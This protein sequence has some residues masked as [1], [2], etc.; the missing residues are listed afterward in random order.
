MFEF[1][2]A[3]FL[4]ELKVPFIIFCEEKS[5]LGVL[6]ED[7]KGDAEFSVSLRAKFSFSH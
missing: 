5:I 4:P 1:A 3:S 7:F 6:E 2:V